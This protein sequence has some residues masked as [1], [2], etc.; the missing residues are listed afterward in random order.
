MRNT[1]AYP[2]EK[3]IFSARPRRVSPRLDSVRPFVPGDQPGRYKERLGLSEEK[4]GYFPSGG[5]DSKLGRAIAVIVG[6]V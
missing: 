5:G 4:E 2:Q 3:K 1:S 6:R